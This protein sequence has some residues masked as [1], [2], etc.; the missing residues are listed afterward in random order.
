MDTHVL[1]IRLLHA[2]TYVLRAAT[3]S[4]K[5]FMY[6]GFT[7]RREAT[8]MTADDSKQPDLGSDHAGFGEVGWF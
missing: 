3:P 2:L 5:I 8:E 7:L 6:N 1:C 4:R